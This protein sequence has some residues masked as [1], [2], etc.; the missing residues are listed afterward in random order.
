MFE[1]PEPPFRVRSVEMLRGDLDRVL[2]QFLD[3]RRAELAAMDPAARAL[4]DE[5]G[6]LVAAGGKR[7]RPALCYWAFRAAGGPDGDA[8]LRAG[9]AIELLHT[10]ALIHDDLMDRDDERRGV[11]ATHVRFGKQAPP[12]IEPDAFGTA[13]AILAGDLAL[14]LSERC[15]RASGFPAQ[16]LDAAMSRF[17]RM[18]LEMAAG[19][20]LDVSGSE[21]HGRV[22]AL[23][24]ASYTTEGP[25][26]IG[27]ALAGAT[28][29]AEASLRVYARVVGEAFQLRD[30]V[31]DG[32]AAPD[33]V[34][35][36]GD[37]AERAVRGIGDAPLEPAGVE[38][39]VEIAG[40]LRLRGSGGG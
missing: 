17:D 38:G 11:P 25:V 7:V 14:V 3:D 6:R 8:I 1:V 40:A 16:R 24:S 9:A 26:L 21:R 18:R 19:Q 36:V 39:L 10:S 20:Y 29:A 37:L 22:R 32:D 12:G 28:S 33:S 23:K 15:L 5:I 13:G 2:M 34:A 31:L 27:A 35:R 4:G 30:D